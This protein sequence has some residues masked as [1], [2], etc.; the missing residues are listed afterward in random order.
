MT[1]IVLFYSKQGEESMGFSITEILL[2]LVVALIVIGPD[3]LPNMAKS[4]G[5]GYA[6]F[7]RAFGDLK[8]TVDLNIEPSKPASGENTGKQVYKSRWEEVALKDIPKDEPV[9]VKEIEPTENAA[10]TRTRAK[11][12]DT[13]TDGVADGQEG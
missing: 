10:A 13:V 5:K 7:K 9:A 4:I 2:I 11:R 3:K 8:K 12:S 1:V 6:E